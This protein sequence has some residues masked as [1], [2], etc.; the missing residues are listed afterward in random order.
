MQRAFD[1][2]KTAIVGLSLNGTQTDSSLR[3]SMQYLN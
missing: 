2:F 3:Q 1:Y